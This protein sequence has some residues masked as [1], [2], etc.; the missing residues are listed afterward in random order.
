[1]PVIFQSKQEK[2]TSL[3]TDSV[4]NLHGYSLYDIA[5]ACHHSNLY[6]S[7]NQGIILQDIFFRESI[8]VTER[9]IKM[10]YFP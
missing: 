1:M 6:L 7:T 8:I 3:T 5:S 9:K 10:H 4:L 2:L